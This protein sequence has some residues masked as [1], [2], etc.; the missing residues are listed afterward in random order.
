[1][2]TTSGIGRREHL[3][4]LPEV[5]TDRRIERVLLATDGGIAGISAMHWIA[6]RARVRT[7]DVTVLD[8]VDVPELPGWE[9]GKR[10]FAA[11]RAV[12]HATDYLAGAAASANCKGRVSAGDPRTCITAA[13]EDADLLVIGTRR[14]AGSRHLLASFSTKV[15]ETADC[16][17]VV[18]P[19]GWKRSVGPVLVGVEG[20]GSD[21]AALDFAAHEAEVLHRELVLVHAWQLSRILTPAFPD[22]LE[23]AV[24]VAAALRLAVVA[25]RVRDSH[26]HLRI[27]LLLAHDEPAPALA[28]A[29]KGASLVVVGSHRLSVIDRA[30]FAS[31]NRHVVERPECPV[32]IIRNHTI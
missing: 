12:R 21:D 23:Q 32:A 20:D 4:A 1:M 8:V 28:R 10:H 19:H 31:I 3:P 6:D 30:L 11:D 26:P 15:A 25:N 14:L 27:A 22:E 17:A 16:P 18:V 24:E 2:S 9:A 13:T 7:L 29:A 5:A